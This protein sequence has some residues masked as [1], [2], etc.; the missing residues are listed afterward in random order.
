MWAWVRWC[1]GNVGRWWV[2]DFD[3]DLDRRS[4]SDLL[5]IFYFDFGFCLAKVG[6][7]TEKL[8]SGG[9]SG[10]GG[11]WLIEEEK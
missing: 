2:S 1:N 10:G 5:W 7:V 9:G 6:G 8:A 4:A 11:W 3:F